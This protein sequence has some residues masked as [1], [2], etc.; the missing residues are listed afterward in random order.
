MG[1]W[2]RKKLPWASLSMSKELL[3]THLLNNQV[4]Y[5]GVIL[6]SKL[7]RKFYIDNRKR[8]PT[9][10]Y[11]QC[12]RAIGSETNIVSEIEGGVLYIHFGNKTDVD[13]CHISLVEKNTSDYSKKNSLV[14]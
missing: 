2:P 8:K 1:H 13:L 3:T 12:H 10:A 11:W 14:L 7:N 9:I 4:K 5:L 6:D